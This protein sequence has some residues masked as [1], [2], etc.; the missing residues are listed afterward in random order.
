MLEGN[1]AGEELDMME[2]AEFIP[3]VKNF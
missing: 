2:T 3:F 1:N